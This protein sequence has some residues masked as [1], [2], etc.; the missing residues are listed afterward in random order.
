MLVH[1]CGIPRRQRLGEFGAL[2]GEFRPRRPERILGE[3][4][5]RF[6]GAERGSRVLQGLLN[7]SCD[8]VRTAK[9]A[10]RGPFRVLERRHALAE[11]FEAQGRLLF[12]C[13]SADLNSCAKGGRSKLLKVLPLV[14]R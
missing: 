5:R 6:A 3:L 1:L 11:I 10:P 12:P 2:L 13:P 4:L 7:P 9:H 8:R 14:H